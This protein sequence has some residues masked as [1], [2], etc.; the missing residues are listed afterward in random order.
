MDWSCQDLVEG[1]RKLRDYRVGYGVK[2]CNAAL[3]VFDLHDLIVL[4]CAFGVKKVFRVLAVQT[5]FG[6][7]EVG[8]PRRVLFDD[9]YR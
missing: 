2:C 6:L 5:K 7:V 8:I 9:L 4:C 3:L 1:I